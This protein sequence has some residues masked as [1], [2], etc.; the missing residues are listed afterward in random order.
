MMMLGTACYFLEYHEHAIELLE[1]CSALREVPLGSSH[2]QGAFALVNPSRVY[3]Q[4]GR[5][6][7]ADQL[8]ARISAM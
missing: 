7:Q 6:R 1:Q 8:N 3:E 5:K 4:T 2:P